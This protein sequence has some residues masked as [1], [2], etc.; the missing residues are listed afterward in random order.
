MGVFGFVGYLAYNWDIRSTELIT[1]RRAAIAD[2]RRQRM[3]EN[4]AT[5]AADA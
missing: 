1:E 5:T 2:R 4:S 3:V